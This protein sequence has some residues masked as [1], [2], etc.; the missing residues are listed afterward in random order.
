MN[1]V[2]DGQSLGFTGGMERSVCALAS[3]MAER[4]HEVFLFT[5]DAPSTKPAFYLSP[6]VRRIS[7]AHNG[8]RR[9]MARFRQQILACA[10][11]VCVSFAGDRRHLTW[12]AALLGTGIPLVISEQCSPEAV[13]NIFWNRPERLSVMAVADAVHI[14]R[15]SSLNSLP[16]ELRAKAHVI[17]NAVTIADPPSRSGENNLIIALGRLEKD[18]Q[19]D[20]LI[21][22]FA[23]LAHDF[24]T[25]KIEIWGEGSQQA[26]LRR[27]ID[28]A[29]LD[30]RVR[31]CGLTKDP[32]QCYT[33]ASVVCHP[34]RHEGFGL[35]VLE[36]MAAGLPVVGFAQCPGVNDLVLDGQTGVLAQEMTP[37]AL[38]VALRQ[39]M[40]D[41]DLRQSMGIEALQRARS[42]S[43]D[44]VYAQW[45]KLLIEAASKSRQT[46][47]QLWEASISTHGFGFGQNP[48]RSTMTVH[49]EILQRALKRPNLLVAK[50][51]FLKLLIFQFPWLMRLVRPLYTWCKNLRHS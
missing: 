8:R 9:H 46:C 47:L 34:S 1:I 40:S 14:L 49:Y 22:A 45:E 13:E 28:Q 26:R 50:G 15:P 7:Y 44:V 31:L 11:H 36:A 4:G 12:C 17:P 42:Y 16:T 23:L 25:W 5:S 6:K 10:P 39:L 35:V 18:K 41:A 48:A 43:A 24:P 2:L 37:Q 51:Q 29:N 27:D 21:A 19:Y 38:A 33:R 20:L 3:N 30:R 32:E